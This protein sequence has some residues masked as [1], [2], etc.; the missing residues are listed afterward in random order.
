MRWRKPPPDPPLELPAGPSYAGV[1]RRA[2]V[3]LRTHGWCHYGGMDRDGRICL[4]MAITGAARDA[5][6]EHDDLH[7]PAEHAARQLEPHGRTG[8]AYALIRYNDAPERTEAD[9]HEFLNRLAA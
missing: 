3:R 4:L 9:I 5:L 1:Y 7:G 2:A 6:A 8:S